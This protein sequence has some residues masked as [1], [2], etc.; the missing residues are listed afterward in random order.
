M[1]IAVNKVRHVQTW[2]DGWDVKARDRL[3]S[4]T[5]SNKYLLLVSWD[6]EH[7]W[8]SETIRISKFLRLPNGAK[9]RHWT[10][11]WTLT[12]DASRRVITPRLGIF[13]NDRR[14]LKRLLSFL[15]ENGFTTVPPSEWMLVLRRL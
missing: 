12:A 7:P 9:F 2:P 3:L 1:K 10:H 6:A 11:A 5:I 8:L 4:I 14:L 15:Y 13:L